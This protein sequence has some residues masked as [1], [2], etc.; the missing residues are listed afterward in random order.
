MKKE[1][2][3]VSEEITREFLVKMGHVKADIVKKLKEAPSQVYILDLIL[4][5][6]S[7]C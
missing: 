3:K 7:H 4:A 1:L 5:L 6:E 2:E